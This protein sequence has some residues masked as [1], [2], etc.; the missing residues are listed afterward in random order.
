[1]SKRLQLTA[2][3]L[4]DG[5][6]VRELV[7]EVLIANVP[8]HEMGISPD[9]DREAGNVFLDLVRFLKKFGISNAEDEADAIMRDVIPTLIRLYAGRE[10]LPLPRT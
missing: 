10:Q 9:L 3:D 8:A 1:M 6:R 7:G 5:M 4:Q 2:L